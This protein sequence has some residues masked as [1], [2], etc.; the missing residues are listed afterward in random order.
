MIQMLL[1]LGL[2]EATTSLIAGLFKSTLV[3]YAAGGAVQ[4]GLDGLP[5]PHLGPDLRANTSRRG[6][7]WG[8]GGMQAALVRQFDLNSR[9]EFLQ[10]FAKQAAPEGLEPRLQG[11][12]KRPAGRRTDD[13]MPASSPTEHETIDGRRPAPPRRADDLRRRPRDAASTGSTSGSRRSRPGSSSTATGRCEQAR[14]STTSSPTGNDRGPLH[15]I[16]IGI[17]DI[18]DVAGPADGRGLRAAGA[19]VPAEQDADVVARLREAGAVILG[20]TVTTPFAWID[21]PPTRNPWNLDRTPGGSSSG[22][23][24]AVA[25]GMCL[26]AIGTQTGGS[27]TR[28]ASF[29]GVAGFKPASTARRADRGD[30]PARP[31]PRSPSAPIAR[32]VAR[33][34]R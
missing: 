23:A 20:K 15:G 21:P 12:P 8:D 29:C 31:E 19:S 1:K 11:G 6:Q 22:S 16:P 30:R 14:G 34:R 4:G 28:P 32:I 17:K 10:E 33:P 3:G 26:A 2:V 13:A 27:I 25:S 5:D 7:S 9:A 24:A 18:I